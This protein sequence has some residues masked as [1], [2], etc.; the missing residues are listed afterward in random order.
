MTYALNPYAHVDALLSGYRI[1]AVAPGFGGLP[2][3]AGPRPG[4]AP[5]MPFHPYYGLA[6]NP[7]LPGYGAGPVGI[8]QTMLQQTQPT[9]DGQLVLPMSSSG[10]VTH[11]TAATITA[12]SQI[13]AYRPERI[14]VANSIATSFTF[15]DI[16]VGNTSQFVQAGTIPAEAFIQGAFGVEMR[17]DT[18]QTAMDFVFQINNIDATTDHQFLSL[19]FGRSVY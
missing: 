1:G 9:R 14:V 17:M 10:V 4:F 2:F 6:P 18:V 3:G 8:G 13:P 7:A 5:P 19:V 12:R 15:S 11:A 16:K